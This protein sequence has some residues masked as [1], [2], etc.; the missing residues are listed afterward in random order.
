VG[1]ASRSK[2]YSDQAY[3]NQVESYFSRLRRMIGG[4]HHDVSPRYLHQFAYHTA[5]TEDHRWESNGELANRLTGLAI[6][7]PVSRNWKGYR[8]R[9]AVNCTQH[10]NGLKQAN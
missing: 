4:Q 3:T 5:W 1:R 7:H 8:Q 2:A 9:S 6:A 10:V